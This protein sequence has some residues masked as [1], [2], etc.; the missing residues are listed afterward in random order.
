MSRTEQDR[1]RSDDNV[2]IPTQR[3]ELATRN[4]PEG[5]AGLSSVSHHYLTQFALGG[6]PDAIEHAMSFAKDAIEATQ[7]E[8]LYRHSHIAWI[9]YLK[10]EQP[11]QLDDAIADAGKALEF[12]SN[13]TPKK[14]D[15]GKEG[16]I[17][18]PFEDLMAHLSAM[19]FKRY[20]LGKKLADLQQ[21]IVLAKRVVEE[22]AKGDPAL[23]T[24]L[25]SLSEMLF[26]RYER[27]NAADDLLEAISEAKAALSLTKPS[28]NK[29]SSRLSSLGAMQLSQFYLTGRIDDLRSG[30]DHAQEAL[31]SISKDDPTY[32]G[33][34]NNLAIILTTMYNGTGDEKYIKEAISLTR[35]AI[36][37]KQSATLLNNLGAVLLGRYEQTRKM[38][39]LKEA[40]DATWKS[41]KA[42]PP[43]HVDLPAR[44]SNLSNMFL[45]SYER[46]KKENDLESAIEHARE[47]VEK[48][49]EG[50][51]HVAGRL[52]NLSRAL[53][54]YYEKT[55]SWNTLEEAISLGR[56]SVELTRT[57]YLELA[58]KKAD[59]GETEGSEELTRK[60]YPDLATRLSN[61]SS[62]LFRKYM[63]TG[64]VKDLSQ[65]I[66]QLQEG[67]KL[68]PNTHADYATMLNNLGG[69]LLAR[70]EKS[71]TD[72]DL[73]DAFN[74]ADRAIRQ[75][76]KQGLD[77]SGRFS[78]MSHILWARY[79]AKGNRERQDLEKAIRFANDAI[80]A[81]SK[82]DYSERVN[83]KGYLG[84]LL[85]EKYILKKT[86]IRDGL[87][88][89]ERWSRE[90]L[91]KAIRDKVKQKGA[92]E[93]LDE[94]IRYTSE[95][96]REDK[97]TGYIQRDLPNILSW[98]GTVL[99]ERYEL[100]SAF[101]DLEEAVNTTREAI[102]I[103]TRKA[104]R[105]L[106]RSSLAR[107]NSFSSPSLLRNTL[108]LLKKNPIGN[109]DEVDE[110]ATCFNSLSTMLYRR[111]KDVGSP[112]DLDEAINFARMA[113]R[114]T[115]DHHA[116]LSNRLKQ[117]GDLLM[118]RYERT[119]H[120]ED[121][122]E[123]G[124]VA[125]KLD[126]VLEGRKSKRS[127]RGSLLGLV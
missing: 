127:S 52:I 50:S 6:D 117:L 126:E 13:G 94:A 31:K 47:A 39:D 77:M 60:C 82:D 112:E 120:E 24:R 86:E 110:R 76:N 49:P 91:D 5:A 92:I 40:I 37:Q 123:C 116:E 18:E 25:S 23:A 103:M 34:L 90:D 44:L 9:Q 68:I 88:T 95:M 114:A 84:K 19:L 87:E 73:E 124:A 21:A 99:L 96:V 53:S 20:E 79:S 65:A 93:Y 54:K 119:Y 8:L 3:L 101:Q 46:T 100:N 74:A 26:H 1:A 14:Y 4:H 125:G 75:S 58:A 109:R 85:W 104:D 45:R 15:C 35:E 30:M 36:A 11:Q 98:L 115:P 48:T 57:A 29:R 81:L 28:D 16:I 64:E 38:D 107:V 7:F 41:I 43:N 12:M 106:L 108:S 111:F 62:L 69:M 27:T 102:D 105:P 89:Q 59:I 33:I 118:K 2:V 121:F 83:M 22:T 97:K 61:L 55:G 113:M 72:E 122:D 80:E 51:S 71:K 10:T 63:R 67:L 42:T 17:S 66:S 56:R 70:Y 78:N 32:T